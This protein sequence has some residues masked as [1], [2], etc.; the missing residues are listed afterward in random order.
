[1][2]IPVL[3][4][5]ALICGTDSF[6]AIAL[7]GQV[8]ETW[9]RTFLK[10]PHGT[11]SPNLARGYRRTCQR[12]RRGPGPIPGKCSCT[13]R[14]TSQFPCRSAM[15]NARAAPLRATFLRPLRASANA[16]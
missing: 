7:F 1:M 15:W 14:M 9:L 5:S 8:H 13:I 16:M 3:S 6:L 12:G 2:D 11:P 4:V 10:L